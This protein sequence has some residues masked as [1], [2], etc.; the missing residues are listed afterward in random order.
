[1]GR[2]EFSRKDFFICSSKLPHLRREVYDRFN[3]SVLGLG[4]LSVAS[5]EHEAVAAVF[6]LAGFTN[7]CRQIDPQLAIPE[8]LG[9]FLEWLFREIKE[10]SVSGP[11][12]EEHH[13]DEIKAMTTLPFFAK[14]LGDGV[15]F[16]WDC[17][18]LTD[19]AIWSIPEMVMQICYRY[20]YKFL[21]GI[22]RT[23]SDPPPALRCGLAQD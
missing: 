10:G 23:V 7:F 5:K 9:A 13:P 15:L 12:N 11:D 4:D 6:D 2:F 21:P 1:M 18:G 19:R 3:A 8:Y 20:E 14:F 16:L 17:A 22:S